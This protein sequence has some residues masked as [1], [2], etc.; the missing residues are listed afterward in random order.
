VKTLI[1]PYPIDSEA[2]DPLLIQATLNN[3][4]IEVVQGDAAAKLKAFGGIGANLYYSASR[5]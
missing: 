2:F 1:L 4:E 3:A 5:G